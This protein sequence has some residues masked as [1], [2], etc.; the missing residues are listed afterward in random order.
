MARRPSPR[1]PAPC[2]CSC[3]SNGG[4]Q[5]AGPPPAPPAPKRRT[6]AP[7]PG[8]WGACRFE[9]AQHAH[10]GPNSQTKSAQEHRLRKKCAA[11]SFAEKVR[12]S[13]RARAL[14]KKC[15]VAFVR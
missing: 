9:P 13:I 12:K 6:C 11:T 5:R 15:A 4:R 7:A 14:P 3:A 2:F 10:A 8:R 1:S